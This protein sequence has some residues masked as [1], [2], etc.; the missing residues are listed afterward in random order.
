MY[1]RLTSSKKSKHKTL[2]I[3]EGVRE[4]KKVKQRIIASLGVIKSQKDLE[5]L[6][7][8]AD[9][10]IQRLEKEGLIIERCINVKDLV[11]KKPFTMVLEKL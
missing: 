10:L 8:L 9:H 4:G 11:H 7:T 5:K 2:Q 1:I 3:V 6:R